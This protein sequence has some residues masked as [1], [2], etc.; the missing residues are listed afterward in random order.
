LVCHLVLVS[1]SQIMGKDPIVVVKKTEKLPLCRKSIRSKFSNSMVELQ[2]G[3]STVKTKL[4][5]LA[6][7]GWIT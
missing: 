6:M 7:S 2:N 4:Y 1:Y 5:I 3:K